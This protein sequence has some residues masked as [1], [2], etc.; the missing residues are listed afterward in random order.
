MQNDRSPSSLD[1]FLRIFTDVRSGEGFDAVL[2]SLN[3]FLILTAYYV[4]KPI[5]E[6][7]I[8]GEQSAELK[9]YLAAAQAV[10]LIPLVR[11]YS[12]LTDRY[13]RKWLINIV[14]WF[15]IL[16]LPIFFALSTMDVPLG[17]AFFIWI[18]IFNV[19]IVAQFWSFAND[20]YTEAE[21]ERLFPLVAFGAAAGAVFGAS[22][23]GQLIEPLGLYIPMLIGGG[24]LVAELQITNW[25]DRRK[26]AAQAR[27]VSQR[28]QQEWQDERAR[29]EPEREEREVREAPEDVAEPAAGEAPGTGMAGAF[30]LL[31]RHRYLLLIALLVLLLN[32]VNTT[33]EYI[34]GKVVETSAADAVAAG[35]A[36][37]LTV[38]EFIGDFYANFYAGVNLLEL[39]IQL[40]LVSRIIKYIG[41]RWAVMILPVISVASYSLMA[42][43]PVLGLVRWA[44][45]TENAVDYSLN[46]TVRHALFLP[47]T[48]EQKYKAKQATDSFFWRAGD[49]M[50]A[51]V[52]LVA[53]GLLGWGPGA[54]A[55]INVVLALLYVGIT[56]ETGRR[57]RQ[58]I[59]AGKLPEGVEVAEVAHA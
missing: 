33:G 45:T 48:R 47:T 9:A 19:M 25:I 14:T 52:V 53:A 21:G 36:G 23:V 34:L 41:V 54:V 22:L 17:I 44:K 51:L 24:I 32:W 2:L 3:V 29:G 10:A 28:Q 4:L 37:G 20:L 18:G 58:R 13:S 27:A 1:R 49:V 16:C 6:A 59:E 8:L 57:Y 12:G 5:R 50:S 42:F 11:V 55:Q 31:M 30:S 38:G 39:L 56:F 35:Q 43:Y 15:F 26:D 46:N 7:L 40:F